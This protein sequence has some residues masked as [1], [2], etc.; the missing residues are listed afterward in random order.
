MVPLQQTKHVAT[1]EQIICK[2]Y[3]SCFQNTQTLMLMSWFKNSTVGEIIP[4]LF[5]WI[6][7]HRN[8]LGKNPNDYQKRSMQSQGW[9]LLW[10]PY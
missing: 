10:F 1:R 6:F 5:V 9:L 3:A 4:T 2:S 7:F 8:Y